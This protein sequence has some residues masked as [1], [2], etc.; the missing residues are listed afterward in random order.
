MYSFGAR[1]DEMRGVTQGE[2]VAGC[3][4]QGIEAPVIESAVG[5]LRELLLY[6]HSSGGRLRMDTIPSL[7]KLIEESVAAVATDD[8]TARVQE[9]LAGL[10]KNA[11][12]A[13]L[14]PDHPGRIP[15]GRREF[16]LA[17]L[18]LEWAERAPSECEAEARTLVTSKSGVERGGVRRFRN[19]LGFA[20]PQKSYAD[21][22]RALARRVLA[23]EVLRRKA[24]AGQVQV[25]GGQLDELDEKLR[26]AIKDL[27]G[28]CRGMY[29]QV[30]LPVRGKE[31]G[32]PVGFRTVEL[33]TLAATGGDLHA[34]VLDLLKK[35]VFGEITAD[36]FVELVGTGGPDGPA[37]V[38]MTEAL[39]AFFVFLERPKMRS[40][41]PLLLALAEAVAARKL[42][43]V[44]SARVDSDRLV[45]GEGVRA[46]FGT[47]HDPDEFV[48]EDGAYIMSAP[49]AASLA[50]PT[51]GA[52][53]V[54]GAAGSPSPSGVADLQ[55]QLPMVDVKPVPKGTSA[56][57]YVLRAAVDR[58]NFIKLSQALG[59]LYSL[60]ASMD[61]RIEVDARQPSGFDPVKLRN[62]VQEP[63][64]EANIDHEG[65]PSRD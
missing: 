7:T 38:G 42:G 18:S 20:V 9:T 54:V 16:L 39:D 2:L 43:Y 29:A 53:V 23:L 31:A 46:R 45:P 11:S 24:K 49:L 55:S 48:G 64:T 26:T 44:P 50:T 12:T 57:R 40:D 1:K 30:L 25:S 51:K 60:S 14:W 62:T 17:Y 34:R 35:Q 21:Q 61:V 4:R 47:R 36:R 56:T 3:L 22:S 19:G 52:D 37:F 6:L 41:A 33:G 13:V 58:R 28:T 8:A 59:Q 27:E 5:E 10:L 15:D 63:L 65:V 32:E